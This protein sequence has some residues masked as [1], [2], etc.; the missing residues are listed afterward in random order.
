MGPLCPNK[1]CKKDLEW[2]MGEITE[3]VYGPRTYCCPDCYCFFTLS[4]EEIERLQEEAKQ[5]LDFFDSKQKE[6]EED[7]KRAREDYDKGNI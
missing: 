1:K 3:T 4:V 7:W 2:T 6:T 5:V